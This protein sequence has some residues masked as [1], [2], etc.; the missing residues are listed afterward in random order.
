MPGFIANQ[1]SG[2]MVLHPRVAELNLVLVAQLL[3]KMAHVQ[4]EVLLLV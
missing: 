3:V 2:F 4:V 1:M